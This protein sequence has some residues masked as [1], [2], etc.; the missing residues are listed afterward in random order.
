MAKRRRRPLM[1]ADYRG[2]LFATFTHT[3]DDEEIERRTGQPTGDLNDGALR[4]F[5]LHHP[6]WGI[7]AYPEQCRPALRPHIYLPRGQNWPIATVLADPE[8]IRQTLG[9]PS[10]TRK[11]ITEFI[12]LWGPR[13]PLEIPRDE[14]I[15]DPGFR[16]W[17]DTR[18]N[19]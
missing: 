2:Y 17:L 8:L 19:R 11:G 14:W 18:R 7:D 5:L 6:D 1:W 12:N 15:K 9:N 16:K 4:G 10:R 13:G 3:R